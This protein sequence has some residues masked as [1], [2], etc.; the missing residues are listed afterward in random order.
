MTN[1]AR[2]PFSPCGF[3]APGRDVPWAH[4]RKENSMSRK[5]EGEIALVTG[6]T[7]GIG[8][9]TARQF[10]KKRARVIVT[11]RRQAELDA[12]VVRCFRWGR[13]PKST[14][15]TRWVAT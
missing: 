2:V 13:S 3:G 12:A 10:A 8:L 14:S 5:L 4:R 9:A 7:S 15:R 11:G 6:P 1:A